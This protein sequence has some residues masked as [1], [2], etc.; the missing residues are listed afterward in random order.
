[1]LPENLIIN[2]KER[3]YACFKEELPFYE[4]NKI[5]YLF[6]LSEKAILRKYVVIL[7]KAEYYTN[8][9]API[10]KFLAIIFRMKLSKL[11]NKYSIHIP[12]NCC[13]PGLRI[14]H[15]G[16]ILVNTN[17]QIGKNCA[18]HINTSIVAGGLNS[19][20][21]VLGDGVVMGVGS[22]AV[23]NVKIANNVAVG[24]NAVV[25]KDV[26]EENVA[27]AGVPAKKISNNGRLEW[28]KNN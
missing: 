28:N 23:G 4:C 14:M 2:S 27:F 13:E 26:I 24:A 17:A 20:A 18:L 9:S 3:L 5:A 6:Q 11:Q 15:I 10:A 21:P 25:T 12:I 19:D 8:V 16:P 22:V 7:R 1:M